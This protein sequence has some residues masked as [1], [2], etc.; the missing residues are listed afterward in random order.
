[1]PRRQRVPSNTVAEVISSSRR[2][3]CICYGLVGDLSLKRG[4]V[5]HLDRD[6]SNNDSDN[7]A[8]LCLD[9]HDVYDSRMSQSRGFAPKEI[10]KYREELYAAIRKREDRDKISEEPEVKIREE[11]RSTIAIELSLLNTG[12]LYQIEVPLDANLGRV[13][14]AM[15]K[16]VGLSANDPSG[17]PLVWDMYS[18]TR[19]AHLDRA[20]TV[21]EN[22]LEGG[23]RVMLYY[24]MVAG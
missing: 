5:A 20:L 13:V 22:H 16:Q 14:D 6:P 11:T 12:V 1:M 7:L 4:Q 15:A 23:E 9:H 24:Q 17:R 10:K 19:K 2:R 18:D 3:C 8:F 21:R